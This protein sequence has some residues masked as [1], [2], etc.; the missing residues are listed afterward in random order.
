MRKGSKRNKREKVL[1]EWN[2]KNR[3]R[4]RNTDGKVEKKLKGESTYKIKENKGS[5]IRD[6]K[7][8]MEGEWRGNR[9][10]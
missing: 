5:K 1:R 4:K 2:R 3:E 9:R 8:K 7:K 10:K 6:G